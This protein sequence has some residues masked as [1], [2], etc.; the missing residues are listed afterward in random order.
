LTLSSCT[1]SLEGSEDPLAPKMDPVVKVRNRLEWQERCK[2][3][4]LK[5]HALLYASRDQLDAVSLRLLDR[6]SRWHLQ[7]CE[8]AGVLRIE[9]RLAQ[10]LIT[11]TLTLVLSV[12]CTQEQAHKFNDSVKVFGG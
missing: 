9:F 8:E 12:E 5:P 6:C 1:S 7:L 11:C 2:V 10:I 3:V 4:C